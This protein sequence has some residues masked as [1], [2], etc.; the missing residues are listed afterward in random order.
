MQKKKRRLRVELITSR[1]SKPFAT[2]STYVVGRSGLKI[3]VWARPKITG[4]N[5]LRKAAILNSMRKKG[6]PARRRVNEQLKIIQAFDA[7]E[8]PDLECITE[9]AEDGPSRTVD[10]NKEKE[11]PLHIKVSTVGVS[12]YD[13]FDEEGDP[14]DEDSQDEGDGD[15]IYSNFNDHNSGNSPIDDYECLEPS[16]FLGRS[17]LV[18]RHSSEEVLQFG[19]GRRKV[20]SA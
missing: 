12:N 5:L 8:N 16:N 1:L 6:L 13:A 19:S 11:E 7:G 17:C 4:T 18:E 2:P 10:A 15:L 9:H 3:A 14:Y 20:P